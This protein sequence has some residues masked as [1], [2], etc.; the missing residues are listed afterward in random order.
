MDD[1]TKILKPYFKKIREA[2]RDIEYYLNEYPM[3]PFEISEEDIEALIWLQ[4]NID[5]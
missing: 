2:Q 1:L 4:E 5:T 3:I